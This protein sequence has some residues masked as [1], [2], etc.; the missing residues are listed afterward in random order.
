[1]SAATKTQ[2][3]PPHQ[4]PARRGRWG[5]VGPLP[6]A[7]AAAVEQAEAFVESAKAERNASASSVDQAVAE[8]DR[9]KSM[10]SYHQKKYTRYQELV[11]SKAIP[12]RIADEEEEGYESARA[13][14]V[15]SQK[16]V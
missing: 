3:T 15:A 8:V 16:A 7:G 9:Y 11:Q 13:S 6:V 4:A 1:M 2:T 5:W 12:Q 10:T 14:E